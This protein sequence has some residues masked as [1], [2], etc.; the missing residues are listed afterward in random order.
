MAITT[1]LFEEPT[2]QQVSHSA[3]SLYTR[4]SEPNRTWAAWICDICVPAAAAMAAAHNKWPRS[5]S[6]THTS[7]NFAN[8]IE[9]PFFEHLA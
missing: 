2:P 7:Y 4:S 5:Q 8:D 3:T 1:G 6:R 9:L